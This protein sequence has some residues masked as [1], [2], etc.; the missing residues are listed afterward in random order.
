MRQR[1]CVTLVA[2]EATPSPRHAAINAP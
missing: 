2:D 1:P